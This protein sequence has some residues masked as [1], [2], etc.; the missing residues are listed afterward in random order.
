MQY[1]FKLHSCQLGFS[2]AND[3]LPPEHGQVEYSQDGFGNPSSSNVGK[4]ADAQPSKQI[5]HKMIERKRRKDTNFLYSELRSLLPE[6]RIR[7]KRSVSNQLDESINY[8]RHLEQQIKDLT[9][10]RDKKKIRAACFKGIEIS[11]PLEFYDE[12]FPSIKI[13]SFGSDTLQV[14]INSIQNQIALSDVLLVF[15]E[16]R[17]EVVNV[18]SSVTNETNAFQ[19]N[20]IKFR[21]YTQSRNFQ[22]KL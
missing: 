6:E 16:C 14:Y 7:R 9:K 13:K 10:E 4:K 15:E 5:I 8:I 12:G 17:G 22:K 19:D 2:F 18:A 1:A 21:R 3:R 20:K 11:K